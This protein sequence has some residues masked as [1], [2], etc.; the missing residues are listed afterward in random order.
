MAIG[1]TGF[2]ENGSKSTLD[3]EFLIKGGFSSDKPL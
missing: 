1:A 3:C 2:I